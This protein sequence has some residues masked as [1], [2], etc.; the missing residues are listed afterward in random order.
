MKKNKLYGWGWNRQPSDKYTI[1]FLLPTLS[2]H[3]PPRPKKKKE[4]TNL[5]FNWLPFPTCYPLSN[6][7]RISILGGPFECLYLEACTS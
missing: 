7:A 4:Q 6:Y 2:N 3:R 1:F 5:P